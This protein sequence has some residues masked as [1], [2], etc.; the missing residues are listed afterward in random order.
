MKDLQR[1]IDQ[2]RAMSELSAASRQR[3]RDGKKWGEFDFYDG[4]M[5][6]FERALNI[7]KAIAG[8]TK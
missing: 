4:E 5:C 1:A 8:E 2:I 7:L 6:G 3:A